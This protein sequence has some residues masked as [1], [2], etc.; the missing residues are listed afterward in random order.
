[1]ASKKRSARLALVADLAKRK[2]EEADRVL[3]ES[4]ER[5]DTAIKGLEQLQDYLNEYQEA[6][7]VEAGQSVSVAQLQT[8]AAFVGRL[9]S[10][11]RQQQ[12]VVV[13]MRS[14]H[15]QVER[16]WREIYARERALEKLQKKAVDEE[17]VIADK[18][19]QKQIDELSQRKIPNFI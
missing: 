1:M 10:S 2:R 6:G 9:R 5:L 15:E 12:E 19:L 11:V 8:Q 3:V 17:A 7:L 13:Q 18:Q 16:W 14:Q 4:R